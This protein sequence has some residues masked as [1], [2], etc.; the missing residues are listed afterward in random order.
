MIRA[1][2]ETASLKREMSSFGGLL[3]T[4]SCLSPSIGVYIVGSDV[5][6]QVGSG[7]FLCFVAAVLLGVAMSAI[8]AELGSAFPH[9]GGE[10]TIGARVLG[11]P[12]G[13]ALLAAN[14]IG[15]CIAQAL[16]GQ[17][18]ADYLKPLI[19]SV[20]PIVLALGAVV[21]VT[22]LGVLSVR[23][24]AWVTGVFLALEI[25]ALIATAILGFADPAPH[26]FERLW[27]P[28]FAAPGGELHATPIAALGVAAAAGIYAFNGYGAVVFFGEEIR[29]ARRSVAAVV[30]W[31]LAIAAATELAPLAGVIVGAPDLAALS[32]SASPVPDFIAARAGP[33]ASRVISL[34]VALAIL[35]AM[36]AVALVGGRQIWATARDRCWPQGV[37]SLMVK[38]HP[39]FGSPWV[40]TLTLGV[41]ALVLCFAPSPLLI[42]IIGN[43]NVALYGALS[44]AV[45]VGRRTGSTAQG[46]APMPLFPLAPVLVLLA[47]AGVVWADLLDKAGRAGLLATLAMLAL[48]AGYWSLRLRGRDGWRHHDPVEEA[49]D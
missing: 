33:V 46:H 3:I 23:F 10:Y 19:P 20:P 41:F 32:A 38:V 43:T 47:L 16:S 49:P 30:Y 9:T 42:T 35:N 2:S 26:G 37:S 13:F 14:L 39:R 25:A 11:A 48:G 28:A 36:I 18:V 8:Y 24:N 44:L 29:N 7:A 21:T 4:L 6:H 5:L 31:A 34:G 27:R 40:A 22:L 17:G 12:V 15:F 1:P 45:M